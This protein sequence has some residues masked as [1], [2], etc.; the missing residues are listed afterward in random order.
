MGQEFTGVLR[1]VH[2]LAARTAAWIAP[3]H[4][5][6]HRRLSSAYAN[7]LF[8][9]TAGRGVRA[10]INGER[11]RIDP[12]F[13]WRFWPEYEVDVAGYLR[14][15]V[16]PGDCCFDVGAN[17]GIYVLQFAR[18]VGAQGH[19][20][21]FE[22]NPATFRALERH[23]RINGLATRVHAV[24]RAVGREAAVT[25]LFDTESGSGLSRL[26]APNPTV[27]DAGTTPVTVTTIDRYCAET[28]QVPD[29][30]LI[31]VEGY[32]FDVIAGAVATIRKHRPTFLVEL[33]PA[34]WPGGERT[35]IEGAALIDELGLKVVRPRL[36]EPLWSVG[37]VVLEPASGP[38]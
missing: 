2:R 37:W 7:V 21:A 36:S 15:R 12:R 19:V 35:R 23:I 27:T 22:P 4:S 38:R 20:T 1:H 14:Q 6:L 32:E 18:W 24:Q 9:L 26:G 11:F 33:H 25:Q 13:R 10:D 30:L 5:P 34:L 29:W 16:R 3:V 17:V 8:A 31:D 28:G